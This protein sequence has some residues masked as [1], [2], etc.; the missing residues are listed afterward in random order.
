ML[1]S[2]VRQLSRFVSD[3]VT[4]A[5]A[6]EASSVAPG[7]S[8]PAAVEGRVVSKVMVGNALEAAIDIVL[9]EEQDEEIGE[10][11][12]SFVGSAKQFNDCCCACGLFIEY[13]LIHILFSLVIGRN[14]DNGED[15]EDDE[16]DG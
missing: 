6:A 2:S 1:S 9:G 3:L 5:T 4:G 15:N 10:T 14:G 8:V 12:R 7:L 16:D 11:Y 13:V